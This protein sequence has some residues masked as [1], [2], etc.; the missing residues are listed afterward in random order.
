MRGINSR[1]QVSGEDRCS[2]YS[3]HRP[4]SK[5]RAAAA[6]RP[7]VII[8]NE[9]VASLVSYILEGAGHPTIAARD[10]LSGAILADRHR[11]SL[12]I[13]DTDVVNG[14]QLMEQAIDLLVAKA[15][16]LL[17]LTSGDEHWSGNVEASAAI[18]IVRKPLP[19]PELLA[20]IRAHMAATER[21]QQ[22]QFADLTADLAT[23]RVRRGARRIHTSPIQ[24]AILCHLLRNPEL[25]ISRQE[26]IEAVWKGDPVD[27]RTVDAHIVHL[28]KALTAGG[29]RSLIQTV[30]SAGYLLDLEI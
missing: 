30:R 26:L 12:V 8:M 18:R 22:L 19:T 16:P 7:I 2:S 10:V 15:A 21:S 25:V 5:A 17:V 9:N 28:R 14:R 13:L 23:H 24:F 11:A 4:V 27:P 20:K 6:Q 29:E 3:V 1:A